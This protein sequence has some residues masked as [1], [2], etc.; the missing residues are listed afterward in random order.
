MA[1]TFASAVADWAKKTEVVQTTVL[2][3]SMRLLDEEVVEAVP[4]VTGNLRN[5]REVSTVGRTTIDWR[6][7]KFRDPSDQV[8]NA[9]AG[10]EVGKTAFYGF[11]APYAFKVEKAHGFFRLVAQRWTD[12]VN[13]AARMVK[14]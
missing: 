1:D 7:K 9:I 5:S 3:T 11:R 4:V 6:T 2:Q 10:I 8:N 14:P 12:I 13:Q